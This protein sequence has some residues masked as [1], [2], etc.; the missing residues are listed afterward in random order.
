MNAALNEQECGSCLAL[1]P[2]RVK[3]SKEGETASIFALTVAPV[4][5]IRPR[6]LVCATQAS[7]NRSQFLTWTTARQAMAVGDLDPGAAYP[8]PWRNAPAQEKLMSRY[9]LADPSLIS[10]SGHCYEYLASLAAPLQRHGNQVVLVGNVQVDG[11]LRDKRSVLP[12]FR[13]WCD[14]R[15]ETPEE[16]RKAHEQAIRDDLLGMSREFKINRNDVV[17]INTLRHWAIR[18]VVDWLE[19]LP[20]RRRPRTVLILHFTAFPDP[21]ESDGSELYYRDAFHRIE[22]SVCRDK[23]LLAADSEQLVSEYSLINP[24]LIFH[25]API[26]HAVVHGNDRDTLARIKAGDRIRIGYVGEAR[27]NKGFDLLPRLLARAKDMRLVDSIELH[28]HAFC[29]E[30]AAPFYRRTLSG[31]R[32]PAAFLYHHPMDDKEYSDFLARLDVVVLPYTI[33]NYHSQTSGVFA[34]AMASGKIVVVPKGTWLST[35]LRRY[36]GGV[37]FNPI[38]CEDFANETL[39]IVSEPLPYA[40]A[41]AE[42]APLWRHFHNADRLMHLLSGQIPDQSKAA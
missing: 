12:C 34:E 8:G 38:D 5:C 28:V 17:V 30:P 18:G 2:R 39:R 14:D 37:A 33:D 19:A 7:G 35:Q 31:L 25:L 36:G 9:F 13:L 16:T 3:R 22:T 23:I 10:F 41:A 6:R 15:S 24:T 42:R 11:F 4:A 1:L 20:A 27:I 29:G 26:P 40:R 21:N 32:H